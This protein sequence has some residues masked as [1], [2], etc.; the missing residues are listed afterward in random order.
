MKDLVIFGVFILLLSLA[1]MVEESGEMNASV[2]SGDVLHT[3]HDSLPAY[4]IT[5]RRHH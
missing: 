1:G 5:E 2:V 3:A 4:V